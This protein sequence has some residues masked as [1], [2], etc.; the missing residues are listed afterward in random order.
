MDK[1]AE[2][3]AIKDEGDSRI[4]IFS[5]IFLYNEA[6]KEIG[7]QVV[8]KDGIIDDFKYSGRKRNWIGYF[9]LSQ[10]LRMPFVMNSIWDIFSIGEKEALDE[11]G[12]RTHEQLFN[13]PRWLSIL[14]LILFIISFLALYFLVFYV[15][16]FIAHKI[17][18]WQSLNTKL[19]NGVILTIA[20]VSGTVLGYPYFVFC[21]ANIGVFNEWFI[22][23]FLFV[24]GMALGFIQMWNNDLKYVRCSACRFWS[25][26]HNGSELV[27]KVESTT[28]YSDGRKERGT[29][30]VWI[31]YRLCNRTECGHE[32]K[33]RRTRYSGKYR[34]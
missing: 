9:P 5:N 23:H 26:I 8:T 27:S 14:L 6:K 19:S 17:T 28:T 24:T 16:Y 10:Q 25:G 22:V 4:Y 12:D 32:W 3:Y 33:I 20:I 30:E 34:D 2:P 21:N 18:Y 13:V 1:F 15:P 31:D 29:K 7:V 11:Y